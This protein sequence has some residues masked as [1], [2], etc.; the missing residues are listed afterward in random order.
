MKVLIGL[1]IL[2]ISTAAFS[3]ESCKKGPIPDEGDWRSVSD[4]ARLHKTY[5]VVVQCMQA[6]AKA[7]VHY[8]I[9]SLRNAD[10]ELIVC[11]TSLK[12]E[13]HL[14][15]IFREHGYT[16]IEVVE[17][18]LWDRPNLCGSYCT[19]VATS[20]AACTNWKRYTEFHIAKPE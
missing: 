12:G 14:T 15:P 19:T 11:E 6:H 2:L 18:E 20:S 8:L 17:N 13:Y 4:Y 10:D 7:E 16:E 1:L 5:E 3:A 9:E